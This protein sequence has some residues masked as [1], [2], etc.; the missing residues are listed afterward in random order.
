MIQSAFAVSKACGVERF[1]PRVRITKS[2]IKVNQV[3]DFVMDGTPRV[4]SLGPDRSH[5]QEHSP[6][7]GECH[8]PNLV[9]L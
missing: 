1:P 3:E 2:V 4:S 5:I 6:A 9:P 7:I 8:P